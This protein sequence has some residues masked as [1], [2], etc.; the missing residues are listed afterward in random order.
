MLDLHCALSHFKRGGLRTLWFPITIFIAVNQI[1]V[2]SLN[3]SAR[4]GA[5]GVIAHRV[6]SKNF[7]QTVQL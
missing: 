3:D 1:V 5:E 7:L 6:H 2:G 4:E